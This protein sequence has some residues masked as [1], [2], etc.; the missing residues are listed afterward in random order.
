MLDWK[1]GG[2][3]DGEMARILRRVFHDAIVAAADPEDEL[4]SSQFVNELFGRN[5]DIVIPNAPGGGRSRSSD[6]RVEF[7]Q[8]NEHALLFRSVLQ[9]Q[10]DGSWAKVGQEA[11][12]AFLARV[13]SEGERL[14]NLLSE[15]LPER[16][17][18]QD[19]AIGLLALAGLAA[20]QGSARD[21]RGL[22]A[23][24]LSLDVVNTESMPD[25]WRVLSNQCEQR[26]D[27]ARAY[28]LQGAQV[29]RGSA[30][31]AGVD[32]QRVLSPLADLDA[33]WSSPNSRSRH[34]SLS[35]CF[36]GFSMSASRSLSRTPIPC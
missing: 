2:R 12:V 3:L 28:V 6:F 32:G 4:F 17:A 8:D 34:R 18:D 14:R 25:R 21:Q 33:G 20:G 24:A 19:G 22:L 15:R 31:A 27:A 26:R 30:E 29:A 13:D 1:D 9:A 36:A 7:A 16:A 35:R 10:R 23:A 5:E 11:L